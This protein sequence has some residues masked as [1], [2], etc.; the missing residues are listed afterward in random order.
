MFKAEYINPFLKG[1]ID[2]LDTMCDA[3][4]V[5]CAPLSLTQSAVQAYDLFGTIGI[6]GFLHGAIVMA[7]PTETALKMTSAFLGE[8]IDEV[9]EDVM[10]AYGEILNI[11]AGA[12]AAGF[13]GK[14]ID[15][16]LPTVIAGR[17]RRHFCSEA[18][19][20]VIIPMRFPEWGDMDVEMSVKGGDG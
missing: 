2:T 19:P 1:T 5:R 17:N 11:L 7:M 3:R 18:N 9:N 4:P 13:D 8:T 12:G 10:D 16:S 20:W 15:L 6:S 14:T